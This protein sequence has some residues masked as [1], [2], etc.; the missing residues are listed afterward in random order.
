[1]AADFNG[2]GFSWMQF[3]TRVV[4]DADFDRWTAQAAGSTQRMD[5][6]GFTRF[7]TPTINKDGHVGLFSEAD[8]HLFDAVIGRIV[9]GDTF[10]TPSDM[11]EKKSS[12]GSRAQPDTTP[13]A[14]RS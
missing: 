10:P 3:K 6:A 4:S 13:A 2:P 7:A 1:M 8:P 14:S 5:M 9:A 11:I 12:R